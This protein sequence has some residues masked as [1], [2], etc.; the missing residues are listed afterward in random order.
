V[1]RLP[2]LLWWRRRLGRVGLVAGG[3]LGAFQVGV[4][5]DPELEG[6]GLRVEVAG[7]LDPVLLVQVAEEC[8]RAV[9]DLVVGVGH[10]D[11]PARTYVRL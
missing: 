11:S 9:D 10:G 8:L 7:L 2:R 3:A 1:L 4:A 6:G 5:A